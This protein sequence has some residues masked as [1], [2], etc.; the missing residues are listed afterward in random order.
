MVVLQEGTMKK[1]TALH[2]AIVQC[3]KDISVFEGWTAQID[4]GM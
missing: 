1:N 2:M 4:I 3:S